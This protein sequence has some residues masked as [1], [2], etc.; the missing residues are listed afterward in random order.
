MFNTFF[1]RLR[2]THSTS[3]RRRISRDALDGLPHE[4]FLRIV[5]W[6]YTMVPESMKQRDAQ[7]IYVNPTTREFENLRAMIDQKLAQNDR[8]FQHDEMGDHVHN[9]NLLLGKLSTLEALESTM[10]PIRDDYRARVSPEAY[11]AYVASPPYKALMGCNRTSDPA[12][13][14]RLLQ[15]D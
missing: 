10:P 1:K 12:I 7:G 8:L 2:G 6:F 15:A 13:R 14:L 5:G 9:L 11:T 3:R 4:K